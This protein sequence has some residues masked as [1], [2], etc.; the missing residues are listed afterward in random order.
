MSTTPPRNPWAI[1]ARREMMAKLT[2]KTFW[3]GTLTPLVLIV[4]AYFLM[5]FLAG[6]DETTKVATDSPQASAVIEVANQ[7]GATMEAVSVDDVEQAVLDGD[8]ALGLREGDTGW[9]I[10]VDDSQEGVSTLQ[11]AVSTY[12]LSSNAQEQGVDLQTLQ[13][14]TSASVVTV[15]QADEE[16]MGVATI[17]GMVFSILFFISALTYGIQIAQ[18]VVE[19]KENRIVEILM[20][21]IPVRQLL[22]GKVVGNSVM[23]L[24]QI[25]LL[26]AVGAIA[27]SQTEFSTLLPMLAPSMGWFIVFFLFGF[28]ALACLWAACGALATKVSDL[29]SVTTPL[30]M[31][32][33]I[34][35]FVG[36]SASG[37]MAQALSYVPIMSSIL[38]PRQLLL[39]E[40]T[41][42]DA[43]IA[44]VLVTLFM[45]VA[46]WI[47]E[48]VYRRGV[49]NTSGTLKWSQALRSK[50]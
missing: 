38:M 26:L 5:S 17:A 25:V 1:V 42:V 34:A 20:A 46:I 28:A 32:L 36:L 24:L 44:L 27:L 15:G 23:A 16:K 4:G 8:A 30:M 31:I 13:E 18:S 14:G 11:E 43:L 49:M 22:T 47:G 33:M 9:E 19:E 6:S 7:Q 12:V 37:S 29:N 45:A 40:A 10:V 48:K 21:A 2:D 50:D 3:I 41:W 39:G 35:Y